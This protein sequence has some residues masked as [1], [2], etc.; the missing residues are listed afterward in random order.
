M[1][2]AARGDPCGRRRAF[3]GRAASVE[4]CPKTRPTST[5]LKG[6]QKCISQNAIEP[7]GSKG[8]IKMYRFLLKFAK[9]YKL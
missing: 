3:P 6:P 8:Y 9:F 2:R 4:T 7:S 5:S 1:A